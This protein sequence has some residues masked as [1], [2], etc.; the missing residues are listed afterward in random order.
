MTFVVLIRPA[1]SSNTAV[2]VRYC[3]MFYILCKENGGLINMWNI[4]FGHPS[5]LSRSVCLF[6]CPSSYQ[7]ISLFLC[8]YRC[9]FGD[10]CWP[11]FLSKEKSQFSRHGSKLQNNYCSPRCGKFFL[12]MYVCD[13]IFTE[14]YPSI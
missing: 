13:R 11:L 3:V 10:A 14:F 1:P 2:L 9:V 5:S 7:P 4:D 6:H 8:Q 12:H